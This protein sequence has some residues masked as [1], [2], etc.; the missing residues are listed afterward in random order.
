MKKFVSVLL[1][2]TMILSFVACSSTKETE[3]KHEVVE[4]KVMT[5]EE[6]I[7]SVDTLREL[8]HGS[9]SLFETIADDYATFEVNGNADVWNSDTQEK[10]NQLH[11]KLGFTGALLD[12]MS[13]TRGTDGIRIEEKD[14]YKVTWSYNYPYLNITY[15]MK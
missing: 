9:I 2:V 8:K 7:D 6:A 3:E 12:K 15:E 14:N 4:E 10:L 13:K 1:C 5:I 11:S